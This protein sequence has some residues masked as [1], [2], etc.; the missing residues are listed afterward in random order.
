MI[1]HKLPST[2]QLDTNSFIDDIINVKLDT[3]VGENEREAD[4]SLN[5]FEELDRKSSCIHSGHSQ[6]FAEIYILKYKID[7][8]L[9]K[10]LDI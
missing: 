7:K 5:M 9:K 10:S 3:Q 6:L 4:K 1:K 8:L 2:N